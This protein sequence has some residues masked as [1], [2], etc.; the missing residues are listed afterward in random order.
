MAWV[1]YSFAPRSACPMDGLLTFSNLPLQKLA[2]SHDD[3]LVLTLEV[4]RHLIKP[5][6]V[7]PG[8]A[9]DLLYL[10]ALFRLGYKLDNLPNSGRALVGFNSMLTHSLGEIVLPISTG[11][12]TT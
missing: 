5:I 12:D 4:E 8:Y 10:P 1:S 6:L 3:A 7:D 2:Q 9:T 11:P